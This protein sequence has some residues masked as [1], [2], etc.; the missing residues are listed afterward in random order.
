MIWTEE[1]TV[2]LER[3]KQRLKL[4]YKPLLSLL[5]LNITSQPSLLYCF[6]NACTCCF[7]IFWA[8]LFALSLWLGCSRT[9]VDVC[10]HARH[11]RLIKTWVFPATPLVIK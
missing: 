7:L 1:I 9:N 8:L 4:Q 3:L 5:L 11:L 2:D 6:F 10:T